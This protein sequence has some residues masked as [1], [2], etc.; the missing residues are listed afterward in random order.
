MLRRLL[1]SIL[2]TLMLAAFIVVLFT[3]SSIEWL[4]GWTDDS[5]TMD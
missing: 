3:V 1:D 2:E 5:E 4:F